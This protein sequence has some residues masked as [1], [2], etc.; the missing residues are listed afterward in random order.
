MPVSQTYLIHY[1]EKERLLWHVGDSEGY[2]FLLY[3]TAD[4]FASANF[5]GSVNAHEVQSALIIFITELWCTMHISNS[6]I[7]KLLWVLKQKIEH[8]VVNDSNL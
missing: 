3:T 1:P 7:L 5:I 8:D 6:Q 2:R 4:E